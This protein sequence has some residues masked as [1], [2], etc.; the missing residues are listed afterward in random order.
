[1]TDN[2]THKQGG[3]DDPRNPEKQRE[4][5]RRKQGQDVQ[6]FPSRGE[7]EGATDDEVEK[8]DQGQRRAS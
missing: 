6:K 8:K 1:M 4:E 5:E 2:P 7:H 3:P